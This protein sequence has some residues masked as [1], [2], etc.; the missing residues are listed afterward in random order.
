VAFTTG[1][2]T[3]TAAANATTATVTGLSRNVSYYFRIRASGIVP[4]EWVD[5]TPFP[6]TTP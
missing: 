1:V 2:V 5:A 4:S 3:T 6:I